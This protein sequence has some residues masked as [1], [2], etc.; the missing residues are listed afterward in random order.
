MLIRSSALGDA[1]SPWLSA[2]THS[3][4]CPSA[5]TVRMS[6]EEGQGCGQANEEKGDG[7]EDGQKHDS[8]G[9]TTPG[10]FKT[11]KNQDENARLKGF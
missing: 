9:K 11:A 3:L 10:Y 2:A 8:D 7:E 1:N 4:P 6:Q 5:V